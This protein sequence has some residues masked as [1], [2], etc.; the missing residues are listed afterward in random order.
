[1]AAAAE[2]PRQQSGRGGR[3]A[4]AAERPRRQSG[5]GGA[6]TGPLGDGALVQTNESG[7]SGRVAAAAEWPR[8]QSVVKCDFGLKVAHGQ[9]GPRPRP[10]RIGPI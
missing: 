7:R 1:M 8:R 6:T 5:R 10:M 2:W 9:I 3:V 4:A